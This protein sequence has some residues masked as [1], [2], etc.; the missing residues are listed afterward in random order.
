MY[1][2]PRIGCVEI[3]P[4][5]WECE[6]LHKRGLVDAF[7][8]QSDCQTHVR[9][10]LSMRAKNLLIEEFPLSVP[11]IQEEGGKWYFDGMVSAMEGVGRFCIGLIRDVKVIESD[12]LRQY[13][14]DYVKGQF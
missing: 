13:I 10:E 4:E 11:D 14:A 3:L 12:E 1:K 8:M 6:N 9:L 5:D 2:I 7:R